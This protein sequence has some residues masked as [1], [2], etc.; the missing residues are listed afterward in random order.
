MVPLTEV[1]LLEIENFYS[2]DIEE[3]K[4]YMYQILSVY[5]AKG[6]EVSR[7]TIHL[8]NFIARKLALGNVENQRYPGEDHFLEVIDY[9]A[10]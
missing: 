2:E 8:A 3:V 7:E 5:M 9:W 1:H 10:G 4:Y 6:K